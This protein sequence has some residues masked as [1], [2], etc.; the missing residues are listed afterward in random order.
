MGTA[1]HKGEPGN[2]FSPFPLLL[3]EFCLPSLYYH[4]GLLKGNSF[5]GSMCLTEKHPVGRQWT[6]GIAV[7]NEPEE[8][9]PTTV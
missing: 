9:N 3:P 1:K 5:R 8:E 7:S 6:Q 2:S 4:F